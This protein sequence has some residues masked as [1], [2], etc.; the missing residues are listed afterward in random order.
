M[1]KTVEF[2]IFVKTY[3][4]SKNNEIIEVNDT[5]NEHNFKA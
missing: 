4:S 2:Y 3:L 1:F 5:F